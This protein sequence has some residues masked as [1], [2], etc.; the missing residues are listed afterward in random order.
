[1]NLLDYLE[2]SGCRNAPDFLKGIELE[3]APWNHQFGDVGHLLTY[4]RAG[5]WND[6]GTGKTMPMQASALFYASLENKVVVV[7]P[8]TLIGQWWDELKDNYHNHA[9]FFEVSAL[10]GTVSQKEKLISA[11]HE[12]GWPDILLMS[13]EQFRNMHPLKEKRRKTKGGVKITKPLRFHPLKTNGY[14]VLLFDEAHKL[15]NSASTVHKVLW[16]YVRND[17]ENF[18]LQLYTGSVIA[19]TLM[20]AYGMIRLITPDVYPTKRSFEQQHVEF[21]NN[22]DFREV[23]GFKNTDL[24]Y[25]NLY[26]QGR[27]ITKQMGL[28]DLPDIIPTQYKIT[29]APAH[30]KLYTDLV[31]RRVLEYDGEMIDATHVSKFRQLAFQLIS[32]PEKYTDLKIDNVLD[33]WMDDMIDSVNIAENK[34]IIFCYYRQTVERLA[35]KYAQYNP[36]VIY[37]GT[38]D[39]DKE[40]LNFTKNDACRLAILNLD[41]G[42][43]G[44]NLQVS[45]YLF[46]YEPPITPHQAN[47]AISRAHRGTQKE[48]V[49]IGMPRIIGTIA[50]RRLSSLLKKEAENNTVVRD[51]H[52]LL[53]E[54]LGEIA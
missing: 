31:K 40:R 41:S 21:N 53:N 38:K 11:Y 34:V 5:L 50:A 30:K 52:K 49:N 42:G 7:M 16:R 13:Y 6:A 27:R 28:K 15:K 20:D 29:L 2:K 24:L 26:R 1:M 43:V 10:R 39:V 17:L 35:E 8:P 36:A 44:L 23:I 47:Q 18:A 46:F 45:H 22:S 3:D 51:K 32:N 48:V 54:L 19:N 33:K 9:R 37:G 14:R 12:F 4:T 25:K